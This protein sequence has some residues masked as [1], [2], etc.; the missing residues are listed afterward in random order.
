[1]LVFFLGEGESGDQGFILQRRIQ[2]Q[3]FWGNT[4]KSTVDL[5]HA[6]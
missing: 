1:M 2:I 4:D 3:A 5:L 6:E